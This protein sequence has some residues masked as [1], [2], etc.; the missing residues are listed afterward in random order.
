MRVKTICLL[1][2]HHLCINPRVWKEAFFYE[3]KG[4]KVVIITKWQSYEHLQMDFDL[5]KG[6]NIDY[7]CFLN[8]I[9]GHLSSIMR[10]YV[11]FRKRL[12][13]ELQKY[14]RVGGAWAI[15]HAPNKL[16]KKALEEKA[17]FYSAHLETG[18]YAGVK[19]LR[20]GEKVSFDFEDWYSRDYL[21]PDK[22]VRLLSYLESLAL[23]QASFCT[24][25]SDSMANAL[26]NYYKSDK[27]PETIYNSFPCNI[28]TSLTKQIDKQNNRAQIVWTSRTIG[29]NRGLETFLSAS[30][31]IKY[32][33][34][35][36]LIGESSSEYRNFLRKEFPFIKGHNLKIY[37]FIT[38]DELQYLLLQFDIGLAIDLYEPESR[39]VTVTNKILQYMQAGLQVLAT[40]TK[41]QKEIAALFP[42]AV[43]LVK[44]DHPKD[45]SEAIEFQINNKDSFDKIEQE[46]IY[47]QNISWDKQEH[48]LENLINKYL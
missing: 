28:S 24:A 1:S 6:H 8:L 30:A 26:R 9:P 47:H 43:K 27:I 14:F 36:H 38:H 4:F 31:L 7:K 42:E 15:N 2:D 40:D 16:Y 23:H 10:F 19:L 17:D 13:S 41:G 5:L 20:A 39:N 48:K 45:W 34:D 46:R 22:P 25:A 3:K 18:I 29:P 21:T 12:A 35:L 37:D 11:R 44:L 33:F 32:P